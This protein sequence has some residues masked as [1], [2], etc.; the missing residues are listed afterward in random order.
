MVKVH[1]YKFEPNN[2]FT[3]EGNTILFKIENV[4]ISEH[5]FTLTDPE[6]AVIEDVDVPRDKTVEIKVTFSR[7]GIYNF[8][9]NK[10][11]HSTFGMNGQIEV[12]G[13]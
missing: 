7:T 9:C 10:P 6:G 11:F 2:I 8:Y 12:V 3:Y 1:N 4:T 13:R 5:N